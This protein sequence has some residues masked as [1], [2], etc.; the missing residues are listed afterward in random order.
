MNEPS[1][2]TAGVDLRRCARV[3][4]GAKEY[5]GRALWL[6]SWA[7]FWK[8]CWKRLYTLRPLVMRLFG[9]R[10]SIKNEISG[11]TWIELPWNLTMGEYC[12]LGP[13]V[14]I[15]NLGRVVI[16]D[17][18]VISQDSYLCGG[19]HDYS[20]ETMPLIKSDIVIGSH[21]WICAGAFIGPGVTIGDGAVIGARAVVVKDVSAWT[22]VAGNPARAVKQRTIMRR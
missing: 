5:L 17:H 18:S 8:V 14:T 1:L 4:Y 11:S 20:V 10:L 3:N 7:T 15:Y 22:V 21:V 13:R 6:A 12:A 9:A 2:A 16:G 19:S